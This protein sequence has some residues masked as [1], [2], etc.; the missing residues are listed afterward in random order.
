MLIIR[1][2]L[3]L[4]GLIHLLG[5]LWFFD[6]LNEMSIL[7]GFLSGLSAIT[8]SIFFN[9]NFENFA[10]S[11]KYILILVCVIG[12]GSQAEPIYRYLTTLKEVQTFPLLLSGL[13]CIAYTLVIFDIYKNLKKEGSDPIKQDKKCT[14]RENFHSGE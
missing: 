4:I 12:I 14:S 3:A 9:G 11:T 10:K 8:V 5:V 2:Y 13:L 6:D 7:F 1:V